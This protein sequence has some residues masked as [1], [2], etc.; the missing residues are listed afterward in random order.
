MRKQKISIIGYTG[1]I[2]T[3]LCRFFNKEKFIVKKI[4]L[5]QEKISKLPISFFDKILQ[6]DII[7]N[8]AASLNPKSKDDFYLNELFPK[9]LSKINKKHKKKIIHLSTINVLIKERQDKYS[10]S[11]KKSEINLKKNKKNTFI[12]RLPLIVH[13]VNGRI[14]NKGN[15]SYIYKYFEKFKLPIYPMIYP[16]HIYLP[17]EL[18]HL[19]KTIND[20]AQNRNKNKIINLKGTKSES[21]WTLSQKIA[22]IKKKKILKI[23]SFIL[24][25]IIPK[26]ILKHILKQNNFLQQII[27]I[28]HTNFRKN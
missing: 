18:N 2:G 3:Y 21:L 23:N 8:A 12:L 6:S 9:D 19:A 11:K 26:F 10:L 24:R 16:G 17:V 14:Q 1:F 15:L 4:N 7:V 13:T 27:S 22:M 28:D 25:K 5:R 20:I